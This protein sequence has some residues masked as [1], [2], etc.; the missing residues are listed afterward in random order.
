MKELVKAIDEKQEES[1]INYE[2]GLLSDEDTSYELYSKNGVDDFKFK[3]IFTE[4]NGR[5][6]IDNEFNIESV[7]FIFLIKSE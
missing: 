1:N 5:I 7:N 3:F 2:K 4:I 6:D